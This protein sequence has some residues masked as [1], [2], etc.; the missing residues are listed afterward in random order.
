MMEVFLLHHWEFYLMRKFRRSYYLLS[1]H[2]LQLQ[3]LYP[4]P[5]SPKQYLV[6]SLASSSRVRPSGQ[7]NLRSASQPVL[8]VAGPSGARA[9]GPPEGDQQRAPRPSGRL[10]IVQDAEY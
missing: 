10:N 6:V 8:A 1:G 3:L 4:T 9:P 5:S 2:K 7:Q